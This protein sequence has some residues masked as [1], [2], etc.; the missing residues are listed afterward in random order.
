M[1]QMWLH[2]SN[3]TTAACVFGTMARSIHRTRAFDVLATDEERS[4]GDR[5]AA[6]R[7]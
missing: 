5:E 2:E 3:I 4:S 1:N 6:L 7:R